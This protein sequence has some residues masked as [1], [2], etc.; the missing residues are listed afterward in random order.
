MGAVTGWTNFIHCVINVGTAQ[1]KK[2]Y[3]NAIDIGTC[4][5][6]FGFDDEVPHHSAFDWNSLVVIDEISQAQGNRFDHVGR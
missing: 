2:R 3:R 4:H 5:S 6:A 1:V